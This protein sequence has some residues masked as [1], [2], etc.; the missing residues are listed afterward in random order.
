MI[1]DATKRATNKDRIEQMLPIIERISIL[2]LVPVMAIWLLC[3]RIKANNVRA[4]VKH[5]PA[6]AGEPPALAAA[7]Q[8]ALGLVHWLG[9]F[10]VLPWPHWGENA[11]RRRGLAARA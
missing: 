8:Y 2:P 10:A 4:N 3:L 9:V 6:H 7:R 1:L 11:L 5:S